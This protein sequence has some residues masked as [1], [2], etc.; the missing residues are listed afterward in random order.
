LNGMSEMSVGE[1]ENLDRLT[2]RALEFGE[3]LSAEDRRRLDAERRLIRAELE[4]RHAAAPSQPVA[5]PCPDCGGLG[6][7][8]GCAARGFEC[9]TCE[10]TGE[11][12]HPHPKQ[13][14]RDRS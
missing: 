7:H 1:L 6:Y 5:I 11:V 2:V 12:T 4:T 3:G 8:A 14:S 13:K 9:L 10:A